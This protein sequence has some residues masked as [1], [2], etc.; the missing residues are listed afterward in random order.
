MDQLKN[1]EFGELP[2][3]QAVIMATR[4]LVHLDMH[5][6]TIREAEQQ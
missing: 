2:P 5:I 1:T 6:H 3:Q 4:Q